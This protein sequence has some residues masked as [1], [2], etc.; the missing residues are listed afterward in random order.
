MINIVI[1]HTGFD[2]YVVHTLKQ[3]RKTNPNSNIFL[4]TDDNYKEYNKYST[5][6]DIKS[7]LK[8]IVYT[9]LIYM[10]ILVRVIQNLRC[11]VCKDGLF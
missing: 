4:I 7:L 8:K 2:K 3:L 1:I 5:F 11:F 9:L 10:F 6:V